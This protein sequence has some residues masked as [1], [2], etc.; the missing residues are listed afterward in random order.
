MDKNNCETNYLEYFVEMLIAER[1]ATQN[2]AI[3]YQKDINDLYEYIQEQNISLHDVDNSI[4]AKFITEL[5]KRNLG[6]K[7]IGRKISAY[8]Q[9]FAFLMHDGFLAQN[10]ALD[11]IVPKK[12]ISIPTALTV[13]VLEKL[14]EKSAQDASKEGVRAYAMLEILY[15]T[16]MRISEL[17]TLEM[18]C[19]ESFS[20][21]L[22]INFIMINGGRDKERSVILNK[23]SGM[24][25]GRYLAKRNEFL[26][27]GSKSNWL[28]P[29]YSKGGKVSHIT[30]QRF[31]QILKELAISAGIGNINI[32]PHKI[33]HSFATHMLENGADLE[34]VQELL[35]HSD[36]SSMKMYAKT[37]DA[38]IKKTPLAKH[39]LANQDSNK[40]IDEQKK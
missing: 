20:S 28:F 32:S 13:D 33:R 25:L 14:I 39:Q 12:S 3:S 11:L 16:G 6:A 9:F 23:A 10:P 40:E 26:A 37:L 2:T 19:L 4:M 35:G 5:G 17:V 31:G 15:S 7:T 1:G 36:V 27:K 34:I 22:D 21:H 29:S 24:A 38:N 8:R 30:R 18:K